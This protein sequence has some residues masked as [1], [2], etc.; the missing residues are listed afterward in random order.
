MTGYGEGN[1][2]AAGTRILVELS[3]VNRKQLDIQVAL[4]RV[5]SVFE[6][7]LHTLVRDYF[8]RGRISGSVR[9]EL[10]N[11]SAKHVRA[12]VGLARSYTEA[13]Q[14]ISN[15]LQLDAVV[16]LDMVARM[17]EVLQLDAE[18]AADDKLEALFLKAMERALQALKRM[19]T[20][21]G[22]ELEVDLRG[23]LDQLEQL[24][25]GLEQQAPKLAS[26]YRERLLERLA[27]QGF[28]ALAED[29]RI[30]RE[31]ALFADRS[32]ITEELT[33]LQSHLKQMRGR[34]RTREPAGRPLDFLCQELFRE[35]NTIGAKATDSVI[36]KSVVA[37]K[38]ELER[39]R[40]QVQNVE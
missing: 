16:D 40:E 24:R 12:D 14:A 35:I 33:R 29:E 4:P 15:E 18:P 3:S 17:P 23:R 22:K 2:S 32:D 25:G 19:R 8:S 6:G 13:L 27:G 26:A 7:K 28:E 9:L 20:A 36:T 21:E 11:S 37:F 34:L 5:L 1:A 38:T 30:I 39:I 31:V 10:V